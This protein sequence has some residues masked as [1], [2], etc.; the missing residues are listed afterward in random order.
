MSRL[1]WAEEELGS[2]IAGDVLLHGWMCVDPA[3]PY[4]ERVSTVLLFF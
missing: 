1:G 4:E 3:S 2:F